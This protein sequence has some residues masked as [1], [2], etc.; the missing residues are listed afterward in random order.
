MTG[1]EVAE[2]E[3]DM[4]SATRLLVA[5]RGYE[6][7]TLT[8]ICERA[9]I[10]RSSIYWRYKSKDELVR[11]A[12]AEPFLSIAVLL[13]PEAA[14]AHPSDAGAEEWWADDLAGRMGSVVAAAAEHPA[15]V[16]A[17]LLLRLQ[18]RE[19]PALG[20]AAIQAGLRQ[21]VSELLA[22]IGDVRP[23]APDKENALLGW[24]ATVLKDGLLLGVAFGELPSAAGFG[25][26]CASM[27]RA[28]ARS[29]V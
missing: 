29:T 18:R 9:G 14:A 4:L 8:R 3:E 2:P 19:P 25:R 20:S 22:W 11:A 23:G 7:A 26:V 5:E 6:G 17:G 16:K 15:T 1:S 21:G 28:A 10:L 13:P 24:M 12:V 27:F